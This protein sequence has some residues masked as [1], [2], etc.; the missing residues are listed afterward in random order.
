MRKRY[1]ENLIIFLWILIICGIFKI[2]KLEKW[3]QRLFIWAKL[4]K[5]RFL[6]EN[7]QIIL[8]FAYKLLKLPSLVYFSLKFWLYFISI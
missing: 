5:E 7:A 4:L 1:K 3:L 8:N 6:I 2:L